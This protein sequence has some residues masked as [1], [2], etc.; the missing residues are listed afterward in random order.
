LEE[1][2]I[3]LLLVV[4]DKD[5]SPFEV[6]RVHLEEFYEL[7]KFDQFAGNAFAESISFLLKTRYSCP[8]SL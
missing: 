4:R 8:F 5:E 7:F 3:R 1:I 6:V 2:A